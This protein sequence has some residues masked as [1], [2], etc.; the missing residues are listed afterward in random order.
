MRKR[1]YKEREKVIIRLTKTDKQYLIDFL[2]NGEGKAR[3][4][5]RARVLLK[6]DEGLSTTVI[7]KDVNYYPMTIRE[8]GKRYIEGGIDSALFDKPRPG[9]KRALTEKQSN[10]IIAMICS[11]APEGRSRW[12]IRLIA[13]EAKNQKIVN[14]I[15]RETIRILLKTHDLKP[16]REKNVVRSRD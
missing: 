15:G 2:N 13:E 11:P 14:N 10:E 9:K 1:K 8:I 3:N 7:G 6:L 5:K 4:F 12:T 16:W